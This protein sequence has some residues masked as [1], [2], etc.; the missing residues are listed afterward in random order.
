[1]FYF[2]ENILES[3]FIAIAIIN[4]KAR[5]PKIKALFEY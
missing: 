1:M 5:N 2:F 4:N 3:P